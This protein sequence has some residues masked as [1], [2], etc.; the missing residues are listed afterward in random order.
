MA[1]LQ[2]DFW[3]TLT[4]KLVDGIEGSSYGDA[5]ARKAHSQRARSMLAGLRR[6]WAA[7]LVYYVLT[8]TVLLHALTSAEA[9]AGAAFASARHRAAPLLQGGSSTQGARAW[10]AGSRAAAWLGE[11]G[12]VVA[13]AA[14]WVAVF[15]FTG[16]GSA[17]APASRDAVERAAAEASGP[18]PEE[19]ARPLADKPLA[20]RDVSVWVPPAN[21]AA[22]WLTAEACRAE[23]LLLARTRP[24]F[25]PLMLDAYHPHSGAMLKSACEHD[26]EVRAAGVVLLAVEVGLR[27][28]D[29]LRPVPSCTPAQ[30]RLARRYYH[31]QPPRPSPPFF[32]CVRGAPPPVS[33]L[34]LRGPSGPGPKLRSRTSPHSWQA[35]GVARRARAAAFPRG[36]RRLGRVARL[37]SGREPLASQAAALPRRRP[38]APRHR[39]D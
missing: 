38:R 30:Q 5:S 13:A 7:V 22:H 17:L 21:S 28:P 6:A 9:H 15:L 32:F 36:P 16:G 19:P 11:A 27:C 34:P 18:T 3:E 2:G 29:A 8:G 31:R 25:K 4:S 33:S 39:K 37:G 35:R 14:R 1:E 24:L 26:E 10:L 20:S 23:L 12:E